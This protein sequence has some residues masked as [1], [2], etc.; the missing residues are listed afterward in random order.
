MRQRVAELD[1]KMRL[2]NTNLGTLVEITF[3]VKLADSDGRLVSGTRSM[4]A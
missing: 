1:G 4:K 3:P 2:E